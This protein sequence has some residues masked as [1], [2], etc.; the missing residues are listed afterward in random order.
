MYSPQYLSLPFIHLLSYH[1]LHLLA[2]FLDHN[3]LVALFYDREFQAQKKP[4]TV[5][6]LIQ[7]NLRL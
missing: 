5:A 7:Q 1:S 6:F 2:L 4:H 3:L